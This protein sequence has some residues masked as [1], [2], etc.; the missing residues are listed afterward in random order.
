M[1]AKTPRQIHLFALLSLKSRLKLES[2]GLKHS[3][4]STAARATRKILGSTTKNRA[5]LYEE[6]SDYIENI[7]KI[8]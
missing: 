1:I 7:K 2:L 8:P 3:S 6:L 4:G 5:K